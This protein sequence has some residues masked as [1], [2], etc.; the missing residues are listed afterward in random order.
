M[1]V[2][3]SD[4]EQS[5]VEAGG[6]KIAQLRINGP[7][8]PPYRVGSSMAGE[9]EPEPQP[10]GPSSPPRPLAMPGMD[11]AFSAKAAAQEG[12]SL[13]SRIGTSEDAKEMTAE[14]ARLLWR[15]LWSAGDDDKKLRINIPETS[16]LEDG[17][18]H[19]TIF[20]GKDGMVMK[21]ARQNTSIGSIKARLLAGLDES[22]RNS[23]DVPAAVTYAPVSLAPRLIDAE[24]LLDAC[25]LIQRRQ[26][27]A[28]ADEES[29]AQLPLLIQEH[30]QPLHDIRYAVEYHRA[31]SN[32]EP[33]CRITCRRYDWRVRNV[34]RTVGQGS[35]GPEVQLTDESLMDEIGRMVSNLDM[36]LFQ[37]QKARLSTLKCD[38][39]PSRSG[40][41][42]LRSFGSVAWL[43]PPEGW[44]APG[45]PGA[46]LH[47]S[48]NYT[49]EPD[50]QV[51][52]SASG[53]RPVPA[54]K[55][56]LLARPAPGT[57][58]GA[59]AG[60][61]SGKDGEQNDEEK[62]DKGEK[63]K[64]AEEL[65]VHL[66]EELARAQDALMQIQQSK[67][68]AEQ[69]HKEAMEAVETKIAEIE[70]D[71]S[72]RVHKLER[73][74]D[75]RAEMID[76]LS[77][78]MIQMRGSF[79]KLLSSASE[80]DGSYTTYAEYDRLN[81]RATEISRSVDNIFSNSIEFTRQRTV[82][83][84]VIEEGRVHMEATQGAVKAIHSQ[85]DEVK[86]QAAEQLRQM[87]EVRASFRTVLC[88]TTPAAVGSRQ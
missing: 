20:T 10:P 39:V 80:E 9:P 73:E 12:A 8:P 6:T 62:L 38:F 71:S 53:V 5:T 30:V 42:Y 3:R 31:A 81:S 28:F 54:R 60:P 66:A 84:R 85:L 26:Q 43:K 23:A 50:D 70:Q 40:K 86:Q 48:E 82:M 25:H 29:E 1:I 33:E 45:Q 57:K 72:E 34:S 44:F 41:I 59:W 49:E 18:V 22:V 56:A 46:D 69:A 13:M 16:L 24:Q 64:Q 2:N 35:R 51:A 55:Q 83:D 75:R 58:A 15:L 63:E 32:R 61:E 21:R 11:P 77:D 76:R 47:S 52:W 4:S 7:A 78:D 36:Y 27:N 68:V 87:V 37:Q 79:A 65:A 88:N 67:F 19:M 74:L 14:R 17:A